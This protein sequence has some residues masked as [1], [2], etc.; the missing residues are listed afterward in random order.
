MTSTDQDITID[1][2]RRI[3]G[4]EGLEISRELRS[5]NEGRESFLLAFPES[6]QIFTSCLLRADTYMGLLN[7]YENNQTYYCKMRSLNEKDHRQLRLLEEWF[8]QVVEPP[9]NLLDR[10]EY[11]EWEKREL[12]KCKGHSFYCLPCFR[13]I[14][15][16]R[17]E[18]AMKI[19]RNNSL[20]VKAIKIDFLL[21]NSE[22]LQPNAPKRDSKGPRLQLR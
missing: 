15:R 9:P 21:K 4:K 2:S 22:G 18:K 8:I 5:I 20:A 19:V 17:S 12:E 6:P 3:N 14:A 11:E 16:V 7:V 10:N 1:Y 13:D